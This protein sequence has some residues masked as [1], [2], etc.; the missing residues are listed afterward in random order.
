MVMVRVTLLRKQKNVELVICH[1]AGYTIAVIQ[2]QTVPTMM[3]L[4]VLHLAWSVAALAIRDMIAWVY[5]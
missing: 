1:L 5:V 3:K 2:S 4:N